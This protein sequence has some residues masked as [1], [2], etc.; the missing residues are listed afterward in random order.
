MSYATAQSVNQYYADAHMGH[1][2][3]TVFDFASNRLV[4]APY[5]GVA[6]SASVSAG[7][8]S[9]ALRGVEQ[10]V[11]AASNPLYKFCSGN[12]DCAGPA[13]KCPKC[14]NGRCQ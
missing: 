9:K 13:S 8:S 14:V 10:H 7:V 1:N 2:T 12:E 5:P 3:A 11:C 4:N 6:V